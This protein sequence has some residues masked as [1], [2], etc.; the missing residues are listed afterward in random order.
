MRHDYNG[1]KFYSATDLSCGHSLENAEAILK[2]FDH[3]EEQTDIN[4]VLELFNIK[5]F[6]NHDLR[7]AKWKDI[8][9]ENYKNVTNNFDSVILKLFSNVDEENFMKFLE[10]VS[11]EYIDDFWCLINYYKV[12]IRISEKTFI[13]SIKNTGISISY[14]LCQK[15]IVNHYGQ[16]IADYLTD[17]AESAELLMSQFLIAKTLAQKSLY[18][19]YELTGEQKEEI[20]LKYVR[21]DEANPNYLKLITTSRSTN[22]LPIH[23]KTKLN[24]QKKYDAYLEKYFSENNGFKYGASAIFSETQKEE[25]ELH[26]NKNRELSFSYS[27]Q[28]IENNRDYPTLLNNF[29]YLFGYT[30]LFF[31]SQ[32]PSQPTQI[33][34]FERHCGVR[35]ERE[36]NTG[37]QFIMKHMLFTAQMMGYS[38]QLSKLNIRLE[39]IFKW[40]FETYLHN[41]FQVEGFVFLAPSDSTTDLEK[42]KL[43]AS[44]I[45]SVLKQFS[46]FV[47]E[48]GIDRD[49]F[50]ISSEHMKMENI[51][52]FCQEKYIYPKGDMCKDTMYWLFS[53]QSIL[54][55][56]EKTKSKY[57]DFV[58]LLQNETMNIND[59][60]DH[61]KK[62]IDQLVQNNCIHIDE[63]GNLVL[64][65]EKVSLLNDLYENQV[66][67]IHHR[68]RCSTDLNDM[69]NGGEIELETSL[70]SKPEQSYLNYMLN[71][72]EFSNG[73]DLR[74]KYI[75]GTHSLKIEEH[76][77]DYIELL[78]IM[79]L[80]II[81]INEEFCLR[82]KCLNEKN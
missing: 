70:F 31:R 58:S 50:E 75:H 48:G 73:F 65:L 53:D 43:L 26:D 14:V 60:Y 51:L 19:P 20:L 9:F 36:Y 30:D 56:T 74:N 37:I 76:K 59:F 69:L 71:K 41:E 11:M 42:C 3:N 47:T 38:Q 17:S 25:V 32:F 27:I 8:D 39:N 80:I 33:G 82:E 45:D 46:L 62:G 18:F 78:K 52:S 6:F 34:P 57:H 23:D 67:C 1:I 16:A 24:A 63:E 44:E 21:S 64:N 61:Q 79:V 81:K 77:K 15:N 55:Y 66:S 29:I 10:D 12:Y 49:L 22:E 54:S 68:N 4:R 28:W 35:G 13:Q 72:A 5:Q 40:F 7:L 2:T